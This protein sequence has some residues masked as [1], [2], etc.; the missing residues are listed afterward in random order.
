MLRNLSSIFAVIKEALFL[1]AR[2]SAKGFYDIREIGTKG[3]LIALFLREK[4][5]TFYD[6]CTDDTIS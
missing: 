5:P 4:F 3:L 1:D 2:I 6:C